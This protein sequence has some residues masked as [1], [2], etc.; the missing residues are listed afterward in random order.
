MR[1]QGAVVGAL[2]HGRDPFPRV[3]VECRASWGQGEAQLRGKQ[4]VK[5]RGRYNIPEGQGGPQTS[6]EWDPPL[7]KGK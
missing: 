7:M 4:G 3:R 1:G 5:V 6:R 2:R